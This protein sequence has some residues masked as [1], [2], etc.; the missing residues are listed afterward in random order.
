M[1]RGPLKKNVERV[2]AKY[3]IDV[4][5]EKRSG[6]N[7]P[8]YVESEYIIIHI[9]G[10]LGGVPPQSQTRPPHRTKSTHDADVTLW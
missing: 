4:K 5:L 6:Q 8:E 1:P 10:G 9:F 2:V 7:I 3:L